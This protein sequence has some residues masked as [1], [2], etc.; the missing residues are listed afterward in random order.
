MVHLDAHRAFDQFAHHVLQRRFQEGRAVEPAQR[1]GMGFQDPQDL[2]VHDEPG[3]GHLAEA[4]DEDVVG[5]RGQRPHVGEHAGRRVERAD[6]VLALRRVDAGFAAGGRVDH[7]QQRG[8]A[9]HVAHAAHPCGGDEPG[10]IGGRSPADAHDRVGAGEALLAETLPDAVGHVHGLAGLGIGYHDIH[11]L[12]PALAQQRTR[13]IG[14]PL[15]G[16]RMDQRHTSHP[17]PQQLGQ[18][19]HRPL[20]DAHIVRVDAGTGHVHGSFVDHILHP[21]CRLRRRQ[22]V[23]MHHHIRHI[24]EH[25]IAHLVQRL[26]PFVGV[27]VE[28]RPAAAAPGAFHRLA[29][30]G[31]QIDHLAALGYV[32]GQAFAYRGRHRGTPAQREDAVEPVDGSSDQIA[33]DLTE[34]GL[35]VPFEV[36]GDGHAH[37][38]FDLHV[39]VE[40]RQI[41]QLRGLPSDA[42]LARAHHADHHGLR[43]VRHRQFPPPIRPR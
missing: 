27:A 31:H 30:V 20:P 12:V 39:R 41:H 9:V 1:R 2:L 43:M 13:M 14:M 26:P 35:A 5:Q 17:I 18:V 21:P 28:H 32:L 29:G 10:Q 22:T 38:T 4:F 7:R 33:L 34:R 19:A 3:L 23:G 36:F 25:R 24:P 15:H 42:G 8:R 6:Q 11:D 40:E 37:L 16:L